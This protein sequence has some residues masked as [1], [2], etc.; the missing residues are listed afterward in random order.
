[1]AEWSM[2]LSSANTSALPY[3]TWFLHRFYT[4]TI[5]ILHRCYTI[6]TSLLHLHYAVTTS[7]LYHFY[8]VPTLSIK[9]YYKYT[10]LPVFLRY[11]ASIGNVTPSESRGL[12]LNARCVRNDDGLRFLQESARAV[13]AATAVDP[14]PTPE[15]QSVTPAWRIS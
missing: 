7:I 8:I 1:M 13:S 10:R 12:G 2:S 3:A 15:H 11:C 5:S 4:I 14:S 6:T 9:H